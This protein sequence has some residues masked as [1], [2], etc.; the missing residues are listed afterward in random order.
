MAS[1]SAPT[2]VHAARS[3][4]TLTAR[5]STSTMSLRRHGTPVPTVRVSGNELID[6]GGQAIQ[7]LGVDASGTEDACVGGEEGGLS[8]VPLTSTESGEIASWGADAVRVPLNEDCWLGINGVS[9]SDSGLAYQTA[10]EK[11]VGDLNHAG[12]VAILDLHWSAPGTHKSNRQWPMA[13]ADHSI[14]FWSQ[15]ASQFASDPSVIFDLFNEPSLGT[16][17]PTSEDWACWLNGCTTTFAVANRNGTSTNVAYTAAGMQELVDAVRTTGAT[18]PI[19]VGGLDWAGDPCGIFDSG[20]NGGACAWLTYEPSDPLHQLVASF[21][22]YNTGNCQTISCWNEDVAPLAATVPVVTGEFGEDDCA[23]TYINQ[24]M[25]WADQHGI[26][27]LA[28]S[29]NPPNP[30]SNSTCTASARNPLNWQL[31]SSWQTAN[32]STIA[33]QGAAVRLHLLA[34]HSAAAHHEFATTASEGIFG[35]PAWPRGDDCPSAGR[36]A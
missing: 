34:R 2:L 21:H 35:P 20:G 30:G 6:S 22:T 28:W 11:W 32:P 13:D 7:L 19:M 25:T 26:S 10:I 1:A 15:V 23:T 17:D 14:T 4:A 24:Y 3:A 18:Q 12:I 27:Y 8:W 29:W 36:N 16:S 33:P 31:L 5:P 9:A